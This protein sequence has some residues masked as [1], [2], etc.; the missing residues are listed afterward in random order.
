MIVEAL[1][2]FKGIQ[3]LVLDRTI[4]LIGP[5]PE[6]QE[7]QG[8]EIARHYLKESGA[9]VLIW[10]TMLG[11]GDKLLPKLYWT[12][13]DIGVRK[14][15]RYDAPSVESQYRLPDVFW[16]DIADILRMLVASHDAEF[17]A[18][19]GRYVADLL[20]PLIA[21]VRTLLDASAGRPNW[22]A[23]SR[24]ATQNNLG[25]ALISL[26]DRESGTARLEEAVFAY[27]AALEVFEAAQANHYVEV[28]KTGLEH[29]ETLLHERMQT[30]PGPPHV[31]LNIR[32]NSLH[33]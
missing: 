23:D 12:T 31:L 3:V 14:E 33:L 8:H 15:K 13:S 6:D 25:T 24:A 30:K 27:K 10:G 7:R 18:K 2:E 5:V 32:Q 28:T 1:K 19:E 9:S 16:S 21:R 29:A 17:R 26:G 11:R 4:P 20:P 22:D